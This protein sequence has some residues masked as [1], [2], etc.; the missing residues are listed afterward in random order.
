MQ[1]KGSTGIVWLVIYRSLL[2]L[3]KSVCLWAACDFQAALV[4][5]LIDLNS[6]VAMLQSHEIEGALP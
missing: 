4:Y 3:R 6:T 2:F 1:S 5:Y